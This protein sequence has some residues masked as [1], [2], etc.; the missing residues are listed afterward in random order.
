MNPVTEKWN[1][2][3]LLDQMKSESDMDIVAEN[4]EE[5]VKYLVENSDMLK[6]YN[7]MFGEGWIPGM[8]LPMVRRLFDRTGK[9]YRS[10]WLVCD[11]VFW[12]N[13]GNFKNF[14]GLAEDCRDIDWQSELVQAYEDWIA[15]GS[16][17]EP[18]EA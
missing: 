11:F 1:K 13:K 6:T 4:L 12:L 8:I 2:T 5:L 14:K 9:V 3:G 10:P 16:K 18:Q 15:V 17:E 7:R